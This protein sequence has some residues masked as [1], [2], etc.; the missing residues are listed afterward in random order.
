MIYVTKTYRDYFDGV[1]LMS[2]N[3]TVY[4]EGDYDEDFDMKSYDLTNKKI[5]LINK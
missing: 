3:E 2:T 4:K 1:I 5:N